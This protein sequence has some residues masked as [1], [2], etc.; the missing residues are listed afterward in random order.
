MRVELRV[1]NWRRELRSQ[2]LINR[3]AAIEQAFADARLE[4]TFAQRVRANVVRRITSSFD[5]AAAISLLRRQ[6]G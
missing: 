1:Q 2:D 4:V 5:S 3:G 6:A